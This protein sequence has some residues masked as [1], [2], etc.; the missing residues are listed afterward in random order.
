MIEKIGIRN[1]NDHGSIIYKIFLKQ[2]SVFMRADVTAHKN[3]NR[4]IVIVDASKFYKEWTG[5][6]I[7]Q[8]GI[9]ELERK[10]YAEATD[11][12]SRGITNP[13]PL[14]EVEY[15]NEISFINGITRTKWLILNGVLCFPIECSEESIK[16]FQSISYDNI[17]PE[18]VAS[19]LQECI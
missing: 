9:D 3:S 16:R 4:Y 1:I 12:F 14:A 17:K 15:N 10:K 18:S 8:C 5:E 11:G 19:L 7:R 2:S 6:D 13:V